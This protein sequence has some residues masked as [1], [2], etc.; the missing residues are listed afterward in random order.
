MAPKKYIVINEY[1]EYFSMH[2]TVEDALTAI[3]ECHEEND[4]AYGEIELYV[5][6]PLEFEEPSATPTLAQTLDNHTVLE[7]LGDQP[8]KK[9]G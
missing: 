5:A 8:P 1:A 7:Q 6:V 3:G 9:K 4:M 2:N